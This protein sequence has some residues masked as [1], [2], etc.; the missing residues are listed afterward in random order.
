MNREQKAAVIDEVAGQIA[1]SEGIFA[2]DYRGI[3]VAQVADL[4]DKLRD[5][6]TTLRVVKN[7]LTEL[8]ADKAGAPELK[9]L[10][11]GPIALALVR[12]DV[13]LAAKALSDAA[14]ALRG[15]L[16]FK[17]GVLNG[18]LLTPDHVRSIARLPSR[19]VLNAQLV[20]TIAAP[21]SGLV[22]GLNGLMRVWRSRSRKLPTRG[23]CRELGGLVW[24]LPVVP[25]RLRPPRPTLERPRKS[26]PRRNPKLLLSPKLPS[27]SLLP[28]SRSRSRSRSPS[29]SLW[30]PS[31]PRLR[32]LRRRRQLNTL[33]KPKARPRRTR[34]TR[35]TTKEE[36][37]LRHKSG[38][39]S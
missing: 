22:R 36:P 33:R 16:E 13:A 11:S 29:P 35:P 24:M 32:S 26:P 7:S 6:D 19:D 12:G 39:T 4:R 14:R 5:A 20:G 18:S 31:L 27:R 37:C 17:G 15:P 2:V 23:S 25:P 10:L 9:P 3:T 38:S 28:R 21:I 30:L 34:R 8:A 1:S